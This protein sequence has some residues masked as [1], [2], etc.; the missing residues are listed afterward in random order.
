MRVTVFV[1]IKSSRLEQ[2]IGVRPRNP[3]TGPNS[4]VPPF[5]AHII[6][7]YSGSCHRDVMAH[8]NRNHAGS[9]AKT[10]LLTFDLAIPSSLTDHCEKILKNKVCRRGAQT[11]KG[12]R[13]HICAFFS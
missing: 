13:L 7:F 6:K 8:Y 5:V 12:T 11:T 4:Q 1:A 3:W 2:E 10:K 9:E